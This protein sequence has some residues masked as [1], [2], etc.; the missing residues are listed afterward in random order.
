MTNKKREKEW[1]FVFKSDETY[2]RVIE[3]IKGNNK[4][5]KVGILQWFIKSNAEDDGYERI[6]LEISRQ[7]DS[8]RHVWTYCKK[9]K[10]ERNDKDFHEDEEMYE[11]EFTLDMS[12]PDEPKPDFISGPIYK[13]IKDVK[14]NLSE[15]KKYPAVYKIRYFFLETDYE[16]ILDELIPIG[17]YHYPENI[18]HIIEIEEKQERSKL[19]LQSVI[20][21]SLVS[22]EED[23]LLKKTKENKEEFRKLKNKDIANTAYNNA[24]TNKTEIPSPQ[25]TIGYIE[26]K[27]VGPVAI[28]ALQGNSTNKFLK[29]L[30]EYKKQSHNE[31]S[32]D[33]EDYY[34]RRLKFI[35][36]E[37]KEEKE[38]SVASIA[39]LDS[40]YL[41]RQEGY[42]IQ[43]VYYFVFPDIEKDENPRF[44]CE[45]KKL[46]KL[47]HS[48]EENTR[49][50]LNID[51]EA[52]PIEYSS[53]SRDM[54][55]KTYD[56]IQKGI[57]NVQ[58]KEKE[59]GSNRELLIDITSG[60]KYP[61][62]MAAMYC[63]FNQKPFFYKQMG[64]SEL[65]KFPPVPVNWDSTKID[66][67]SIFFHILKD[68][69]IQYSKYITLP[70]SIKN[71]FDFAQ[72]GSK[73]KSPDL[74]SLLKLDAI[75]KAYKETKKL[76]LGYGEDFLKYIENDKWREYV[77]KKIR[78]KW[79][80][81][82]IGDQIPET[83]EHSQRHSKRLMEFAY[84]MINII[85]KDIFLKGIPEK[86]HDH[87]FFILAVAMNVHDLGH[88]N[89]IWYFENDR[90]M[91][92]DGLPGVVRDLHNELT[93]QM[94]DE[95]KRANEF[96]LL[97]G[98]GK[99]IKEEELENVIKAIKLVCK[100]HR[101]YLRIKEKGG[102]KKR[103]A[104]IF[105]LDITPL[106]KVL[107]KTFK[108]DT[109]WIKL[110]Q[111][112][113][114]WL[115]FID[116]TDVQADRAQSEPYS[117]IRTQRTTME[118][119][120]IGT[121]LLNHHNDYLKKLKIEFDMR[122]T[123]EMLKAFKR[124]QKNIQLGKNLEKK[125]K[126]IE[127]II[128]NVIEETVKQGTNEEY[129]RIPY[130]LK[131][132]AKFAFK[133]RQFPHFDKHASVL[134]GYPRFYRE[135]YTKNEEEQGKLF[136][137]YII[138]EGKNN[139]EQILKDDVKEE[140]ETALI[141]EISSD[142]LKSVEIEVIPENEL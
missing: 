87:F 36:K 25:K 37:K 51:C 89:T 97:E 121:E 35:D 88:T 57:K 106:E 58:G 123:L 113:T 74:V 119:Y 70:Q 39:E 11:T 112:A 60:Q 52:I 104:E 135:K 53:K 132:L 2:Q 130:Q 14:K 67:Y 122:D 140:F 45:E 6:R 27:L 38:T 13:I 95:N 126:I 101:G 28:L 55:N 129:Y 5:K 19:D 44:S 24:N 63:M 83:V 133:I 115:R 32:L 102:K 3:D 31:K 93:I 56:E 76:P 73:N 9:E 96:K 81:Q 18:T 114:Q 141:S 61:G 20:N 10:V 71:I 21:D 49:L 34:H 138:K 128:Y 131:Q 41:L 4:I 142:D 72:S 50:F 22:F 105:L 108:N 136:I 79:S 16:F 33:Y 47:Y 12:K 137:Q 69:N 127:D 82:W 23:D 66:G 111:T 68:Q 107:A 17:E 98:L 134:M 62:I 99:E 110:T 94:L 80:L 85:G 92:L 91:F 75:K 124:D 64:S 100:Y 8:Y 42:D 59:A 15:L 1:K 30:N 84:N 118:S 26:N 90:K 77:I 117:K 40:L 54:I 46:P 103:F 109:D 65:I 86:L 48:L 7:K 120:N 116:G 125:G 139:V 29:D 43:K 78:E